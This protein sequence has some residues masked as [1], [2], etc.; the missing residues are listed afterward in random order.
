M[1]ELER[2][3][4]TE[5]KKLLHE[6]ITEHFMYTGSRNAKRIL[7]AWDSILPKFVKIMPSTISA[8]WK[9]GNGKQRPKAVTRREH[10]YEHG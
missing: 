3:P 8:C 7:D 9:N 5:D 10:G 1:V 2:W 4:T 6:M